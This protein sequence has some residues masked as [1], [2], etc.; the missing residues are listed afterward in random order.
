MPKFFLSP[1][2][3]NFRILQDIY[4]TLCDKD[5][6]VHLKCPGSNL[7]ISIHKCYIFTSSMIKTHITSKIYAF[8]SL[9][10]T[11]YTFVH[12][13]ILITYLCTCIRTTI[14][15]EYYFNRSVTLI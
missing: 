3:A 8:V 6:H 4:I 5:L 14:V 15:N 11:S 9:M 10:K 2:Y 12:T 7:I 1:M 13:D